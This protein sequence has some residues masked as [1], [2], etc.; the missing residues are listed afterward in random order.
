MTKGRITI[1]LVVPPF[2]CCILN[3]IYNANEYIGFGGLIVSQ[4]FF[5]FL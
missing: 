5:V 3:M 2:V 1:D 4:T